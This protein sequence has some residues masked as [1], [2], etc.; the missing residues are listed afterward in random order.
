MA[1]N[2]RI[3]FSGD[4]IP[5]KVPD[6]VRLNVAKLFGFDGENPDHQTKLDKLF[7]GRPVVIKQNLDER[8][9]HNY[10][11]A[12]TKA[13]AIALI[14]KVEVKAKRKLGPKGVERRKSARRRGERRTE[15]R[16]FSPFPDRRQSRGRRS[17]DNPDPD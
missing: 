9:A 10:Q 1:K 16:A 11:Q 5:G 3:I 2:Y 14:D 8:G 12:L 15:H 6:Q 17:N 4:I 13:G 7:S